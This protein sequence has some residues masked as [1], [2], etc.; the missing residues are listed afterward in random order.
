MQQ[1]YVTDKLFL[2]LTMLLYEW[3]G[4]TVKPFTM[5]VLTLIV[6]TAGVLYIMKNS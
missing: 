5:L 3:T 2:P 1:D 6:G 4:V